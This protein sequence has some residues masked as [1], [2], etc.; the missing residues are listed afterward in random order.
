EKSSK[1]LARAQEIIDSVGTIG[2]TTKANHHTVYSMYYK[3]IGDW[4]KALEH[5]EFAMN[6]YKLI[7]KSERNE[8]LSKWRIRLDMEKKE[9]ELNIRDQEPTARTTTI[10]PHKHLYIISTISLFLF[11]LFSYL[12]YKNYTKQHFLSKKNAFLIPEQNNRVKKN[13]QII[14]SILNLQEEHLSDI[15]SEERRVGKECR[16]RW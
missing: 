9:I 15:R 8:N 6:F 3:K 1:V 2:L 10:L 13:L 14:S 11:G 16:S 4:Q 7:A 12:L 5:H